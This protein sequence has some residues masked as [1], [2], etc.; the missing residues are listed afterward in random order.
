MAFTMGVAEDIVGPDQLDKGSAETAEVDSKELAT[1]I[2]ERVWRQFPMQHVADVV[3]VVCP[4]FKDTYCICK[5]GIII[6]DIM[7]MCN[8]GGGGGGGLVVATICTYIECRW[9]PEKRLKQRGRFVCFSFLLRY[10]YSTARREL[11]Y[12]RKYRMI[13]MNSRQYCNTTKI[14]KQY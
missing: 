9:L 2:V 8:G 6:V 12:L 4:T 11:W 7:E 14:T 5:S 10:T 3:D 1:K 13:K